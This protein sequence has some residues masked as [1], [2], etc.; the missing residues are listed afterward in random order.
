MA[1]AAKLLL[2]EMADKNPSKDTEDQLIQVMHIHSVCVCVLSRQYT[3]VL[4]YKEIIWEVR[5]A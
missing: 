5:M 3:Y 1:I 2:R 4:Y